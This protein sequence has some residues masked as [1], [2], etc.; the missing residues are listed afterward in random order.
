MDE[1]TLKEQVIDYASDKRYF[2]IEDVKKF[3]SGKGIDFNEDTVKKT[4]YRLK[5]MA[6]IYGAGRGWYSTIEKEFAL[7]TAPVEKIKKLLESK[8]PLMKFSCWSTEQLRRFFHHV[9]SRFVTF[10]YSDRD[11]LQ[12]LKDHLL[13]NGYNVYLDPAGSETAKYV[14]LVNQTVILRPMISYRGA[15]NGQVVSIEEIIVDLYME[16]KMLNLLDLEEYKR[17]VS[18]IISEYRMNMAELIDNADRRGLRE[19]LRNIIADLW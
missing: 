17:I 1:K 8:F 5:R 2:H 6:V 3:L 11:F 18:R 4:L 16:A 14:D 9:P 15:R 12:P 10:V 7:D 19:N 13:D